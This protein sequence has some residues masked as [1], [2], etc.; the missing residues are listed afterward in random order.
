MCENSMESVGMNVGSEESIL[1][2]GYSPSGALPE[3]VR[4]NLMNCC[5]TKEKTI[6][7]DWMW[8]SAQPPTREM[9]LEALYWLGRR[10]ASADEELLVLQFISDVTEY[11]EP[12]G[13]GTLVRNNAE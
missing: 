5:L 3:Q 9:A 10:A 13:E 8:D 4:Q 1:P 12:H 6:W 7:L 2:P 11:L